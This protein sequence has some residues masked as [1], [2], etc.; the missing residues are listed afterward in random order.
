MLDVVT[1]ALHAVVLQSAVLQVTCL[2]F[3]KKKINLLELIPHGMGACEPV[4]AFSCFLF[5]SKCWIFLKWRE[6]FEI[7]YLFLKIDETWHM[8]LRG[9]GNT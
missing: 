4:K 2:R 8:C 6:Q 5:L 1:F 7:F 3:G 9:S